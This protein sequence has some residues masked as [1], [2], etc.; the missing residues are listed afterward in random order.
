MSRLTKFTLRYHPNSSERLGFLCYSF[1]NPAKRCSFRKTASAI[2]DG[3]GRRL[4]ANRGDSGRTQSPRVCLKYST[5]RRGFQN[6]ANTMQA[7]GTST[8]ALRIVAAGLYFCP[9]AGV[10]ELA[11]TRDSKS[12]GINFPCGFESHLRY[13]RTPCSYGVFFFVATVAV[14]E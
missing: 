8:A 3:N 5:V 13:R 4:A 11:D 2:Q 10:V 9:F 1:V 12:R 7:S 14:A 6:R